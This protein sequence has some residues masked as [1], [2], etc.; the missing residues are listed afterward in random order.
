MNN[1]TKFLIT[2]AFIGFTLLSI[3]HIGNFCVAIQDVSTILKLFLAELELLI[4][5]GCIWSAGIY[6]QLMKKKLRF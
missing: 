4:S 5:F 1:L 6:F 2:T 3:L